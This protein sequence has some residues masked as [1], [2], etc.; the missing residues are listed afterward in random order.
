M[1]IRLHAPGQYA[2]DSESRD[3]SYIVDL[4]ANTCSCPHSTY[5]QAPDCKHRQAV[6]AHIAEQTALG[7][8]AE[9]AA[10]MTESDLKL[11]AERKNGTAAGAACLLELAC[12][13]MSQPKP[14]PQPIPEG[15]LALLEGAT[16]A[17][18]ERALAIYGG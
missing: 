12:R 1:N 14:E 5:R 16:E 13:Q 7:R 4:K 8:A 11:W 17:E 6:R 10:G 18:R 9:K 2:I 15:V 3:A